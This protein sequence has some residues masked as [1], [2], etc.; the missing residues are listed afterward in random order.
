M[1]LSDIPFEIEKLKK[2]YNTND[3]YKIACKK[4]IQILY[5]YFGREVYGFYTKNRK[6][7]FL[8]LNIE[9]DPHAQLFV[10]AHELTHAVFHPNANTAQMTKKSFASVS[11]IEAQ[12]NCGATHLLM[13]GSHTQELYLPTKKEIIKYYG[14][15]PEMERFL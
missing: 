1:L 3:P 8:H 9:L 15:P 6:Q 7:K 2:R 5:G 13:D 14:L 12:A 4:N 10:C 11:K